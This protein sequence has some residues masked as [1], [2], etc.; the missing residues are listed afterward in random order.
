V[1]AVHKEISN[2]EGSDNGEKRGKK[3]GGGEG[4]FW[5]DLDSVVKT[6]STLYTSKVK[7]QTERPATPSDESMLSGDQGT[8]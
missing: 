1:S 3:K 2:S 6:N 8:G 7:I 4:G 5:M